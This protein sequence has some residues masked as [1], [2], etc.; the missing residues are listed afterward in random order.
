MAILDLNKLN[1]KKE[2]FEVR[3]GKKTFKIPLAQDISV[4]QYTALTEAKA[5]GDFEKIKLFLS[6]Y[7]ENE[8]L[9]EMPLSSIGIIFDGWARASNGEKGDLTPGES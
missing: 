4:K 1:Q 8:T 6:Q 3:F 2:V 9:E 7:I 5:S